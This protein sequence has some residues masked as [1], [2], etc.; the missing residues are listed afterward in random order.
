MDTNR[1]PHL[2]L[3]VICVCEAHSRPRCHHAK[4]FVVA[5]AALG[6]LEV[7]SGYIPALRS[8]GQGRRVPG[9]VVRAVEGGEG[10]LLVDREVRPR[11]F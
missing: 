10:S 2:S 9:G 7:P 6:I 1:L 5:C 4:R 8:V 11:V 3:G